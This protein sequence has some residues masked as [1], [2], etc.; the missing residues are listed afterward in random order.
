MGQHWLR[1]AQLHARVQRVVKK[2]S[3]A[4]QEK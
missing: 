2:Q 1:V 4:E 3:R